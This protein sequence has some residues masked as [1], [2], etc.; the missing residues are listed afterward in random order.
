MP[1][2]SCSRVVVRR[3]GISLAFCSF[4]SEVTHVLGQLAHADG[5]GLSLDVV[6]SVPPASPVTG[7]EVSVGAGLYLHCISI[8]LQ[9][10]D[11]EDFPSGHDFKH[12]SCTAGQQLL[13]RRLPPPLRSRALVPPP[14]KEPRLDFTSC[15]P[16]PL[17]R[18]AK[19]AGSRAATFRLAVS[20]S[21]ELLNEVALVG[22]RGV[23]SSPRVSPCLL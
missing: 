16:C 10:A 12:A 1:L 18:A 21:W 22:P 9:N 4:Y 15:R 14:R 13:Q 8:H 7:N 19:P 3:T 11:L 23:F 17:W 20:F 5:G 2:W 6:D